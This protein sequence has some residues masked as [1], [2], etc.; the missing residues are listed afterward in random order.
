MAQ[1]SIHQLTREEHVKAISPDNPVN[2]VAVQAIAAIEES[3]E[4]K[5]GAIDFSI[6]PFI[7][8]SPFF[9]IEPIGGGMGGLNVDVAFLDVEEG[10]QVYRE[11]NLSLK[12]G[13]G[14]ID[15]P[16]EFL[17]ALSKRTIKKIRFSFS[18]DKGNIAEDPDGRIVLQGVKV[19]SWKEDTSSKFSILR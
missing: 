8:G 7:Y 6:I 2:R 1:E 14:D 19:A 12:F 4:A 18:A 13:T 15:N 3:L 17:D 5:S 9:D 16:G 10:E 11:R